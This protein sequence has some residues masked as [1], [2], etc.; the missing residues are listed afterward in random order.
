MYIIV[1]YCSDAHF[2]LFICTLLFYLLLFFG[3]ILCYFD[4]MLP[5]Y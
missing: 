2:Y 3:S 5:E 1:F 4:K